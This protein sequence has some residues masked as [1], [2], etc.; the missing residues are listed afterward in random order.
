MG[1][2]YAALT[3]KNAMD[4]GKVREGLIAE[5]EIRQVAVMSMVDTGTGTLIINELTCQQLGLAIVGLRRSTYA[6]GTKELCKVT[7]PV[8]IHWN[9]RVTSCRAVVVPST[10]EVLLGA[11]PLEDMDLIVHPARRELTGA[12]GD[13]VVCMIK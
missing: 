9:D 7:E 4:V 5:R 6:N 1:T 3:L 13:E 8:D 2:V 11:I 12:H 10:D